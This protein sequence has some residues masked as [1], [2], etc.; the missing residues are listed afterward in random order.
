MS[1]ASV[2][3]NACTCD[4]SVAEK[5]TVALGSGVATTITLANIALGQTL[6][7]TTFQPGSGTPGTITWAGSTVRW[8]GGTAGAPTATLSQGDTFVFTCRSTGIIAGAVALS[9]F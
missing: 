3:A 9:N 8:S 7:I 5:W 4:A 2:T 6:E 1:A